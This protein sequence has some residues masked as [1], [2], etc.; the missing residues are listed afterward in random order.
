MED[1]MTTEKEIRVLMRKLPTWKLGLII[2]PLVTDPNYPP[3]ELKE[4]VKIA[5]EELLYRGKGE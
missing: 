1:K 4:K 2:S 5:K 3:E